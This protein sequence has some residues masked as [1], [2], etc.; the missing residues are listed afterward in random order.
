MLQIINDN[1]FYTKIDSPKLVLVDF[2]ATWCNPC[3]MFFPVL[4]NV[5]NEMQDV[6][7]IFKMNIEDNT[8]IPT[9]LC[10]RGIPTVIMFKDKSQISVR[11]GFQ[12]KQKLVSWI[13]EHLKTTKS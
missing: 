11:S 4:E 3:Q 5:S 13:N 12:D 9:E 1:D 10:I 7:E 2:W 8:K 6:V